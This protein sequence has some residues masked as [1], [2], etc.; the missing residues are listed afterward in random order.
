MLRNRAGCDGFEWN[1]GFDQKESTDFERSHR[2]RADHVLTDG[3]SRCSGKGMCRERSALVSS[4]SRKQEQT[5]VHRTSRRYRGDDCMASLERAK[6]RRRS[7]R[8]MPAR[9][10]GWCRHSHASVGTRAASSTMLSHPATTCSPA[11]LRLSMIWRLTSGRGAARDTEA[12]R[13]NGNLTTND[14]E[15]AVK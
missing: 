1:H 15:I 2:L 14:G 4:I 3:A 10:R 11:P 7:D 12:V 5:R 9:L 13:I 8:T 6:C